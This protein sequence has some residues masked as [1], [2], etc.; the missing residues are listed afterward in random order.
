MPVAFTGRDFIETLD[1]SV[2]EIKVALALA[3]G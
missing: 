1:S 2:E 3:S